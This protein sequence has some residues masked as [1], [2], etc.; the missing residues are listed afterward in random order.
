MH[1]TLTENVQTRMCYTGTKL[2]T[3]FNNIKDPVKKLHQHDVGYYA[4]CPE[5]GC[6]EDNTGETDR[7]LNERVIDHSGRDKKSHLYKHLQKS[8]HPWVAMSVFKIIGSKIKS[9]KE[10][11]LSHC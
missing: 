5:P 10:K 11:L 3:E 6:I 2:G 9:L 1:H 8:K 7:R 4:V